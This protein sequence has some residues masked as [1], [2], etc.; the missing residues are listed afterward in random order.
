MLLLYSRDRN[1]NL[2]VPVFLLL[3]QCKHDR[4][5]S[6]VHLGGTKINNRFSLVGSCVGGEGREFI[7]GHV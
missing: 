1:L 6:S 7:S 3:A 2:I 5:D 4:S